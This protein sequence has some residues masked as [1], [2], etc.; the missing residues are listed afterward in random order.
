MKTK[1]L[2]SIILLL[3]LSFNIVSLPILADDIMPRWQNIFSVTINHGLDDSTACCYVRVKAYSG[4]D[5][6]DNI[7]INLYQM[8]GSALILVASWNDLSTTGD[9]FTFYD[10][11]SDVV[12]GYT[13]RLAITADVH[14][15]GYVEQ[16]DTYGDVA[17]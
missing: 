6:I 7:D 8:V 16:L 5:K 9:E 3:I 11:V 14:R 2:L 1:K 15:Y 10:E 12:G 4:T 17:Y 13:Y